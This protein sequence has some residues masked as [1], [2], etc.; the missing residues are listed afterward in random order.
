MKDTIIKEKED[1]T[2][3]VFAGGKEL[4]DAVAAA[5][6]KEELR[7]ILNRGNIYEF[8]EEE[9]E[10]SYKNLALSQNWDTLM[11]IF[12]DKDFE[13]CR[14]KLEFYG[15]TTTKEHFDLIN[16][17]IATAS[18]EELIKEILKKEDVESTLEVLHR[19]G[20]DKM[21]SEF[22]LLVQENAVHLYEDALLTSEEIQEL[23]GKDFYER[24][25]K[26]IN[27]I[28]ALSSIAGLGLGISS[29][30]DPALLIAIAGGLSLMFGKEEIRS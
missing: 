4:V 25:K 19:Y 26:S 12:Q 20:Y 1:G 21:T 17:V 27:L 11:D 3:E 18:D 10:E 30:A 29:V 14:R 9:L 28:F 8:S 6:S 24:C 5:S 23:S 22:L 13:S 7:K 15:I 2:K 16:E